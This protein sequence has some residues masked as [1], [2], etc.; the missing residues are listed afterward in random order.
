MEIF[1]ATI[2][3][4]ILR[5]WQELEFEYSIIEG[6]IITKPLRFTGKVPGNIILTYCMEQSPSSEANRFSASQEILRILWNPTVHY[7]ITSA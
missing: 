1:N 4:K 7:R 3:F 6:L 5:L 2:N